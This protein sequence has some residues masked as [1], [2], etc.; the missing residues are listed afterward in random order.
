LFNAQAT[1]VLPLLS[2]ASILVVRDTLTVC[3]AVCD[4]EL[5]LPDH[6]LVRFIV[7]LNLIA[8]MHLTE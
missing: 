6:V 5:A 1:S 8:R 3:N 4:A 7:C 2:M